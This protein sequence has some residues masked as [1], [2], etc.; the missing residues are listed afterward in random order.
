[1]T[2]AWEEPFGI[3]ILNIYNVIAGLQLALTNPFPA[4][5]VSVLFGASVCLGSKEACAAT[6]VAEKNFISGAAYINLVIS[7]YP[8]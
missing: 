4:N 6:V 7:L 5:I 8:L 3:P 1:M 2:G